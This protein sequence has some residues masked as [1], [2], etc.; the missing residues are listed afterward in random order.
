MREAQENFA[1]SSLFLALT[2]HFWLSQPIYTQVVCEIQ[3]IQNGPSS[4]PLTAWQ[5]SKPD[6]FIV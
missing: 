3:D 2:A 6:N 1:F 5:F 4:V